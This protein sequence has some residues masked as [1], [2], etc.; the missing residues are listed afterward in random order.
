VVERTIEEVGTGG[1]VAL[2]DICTECPLAKAGLCHPGFAWGGRTGQLNISGER[3]DTEGCGLNG[4]EKAPEY[5]PVVV[6]VPLEVMD[7]AR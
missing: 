7:S 2:A 6:D 5:Q 3:L 1:M 4:V